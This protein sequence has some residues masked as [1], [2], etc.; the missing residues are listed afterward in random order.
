LENY[1][2]AECTEGFQK[3]TVLMFKLNNFG[4][5]QSKL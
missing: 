3:L 4:Q 1:P 5:F 2:Q